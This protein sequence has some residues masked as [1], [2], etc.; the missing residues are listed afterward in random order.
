MGPPKVGGF[1]LITPR[2]SS[3]RSRDN[4]RRGLAAR[5]LPNLDFTALRRLSQRFRPY[6]LHRFCD[7]PEL[8]GTPAQWTTTSCFSRSFFLNSSPRR[9]SRALRVRWLVVIRSRSFRVSI[10]K[11]D[12][13]RQNVASFWRILSRNQLEP[14]V[15]DLGQDLVIG[16]RLFPYGQDARQALRWSCQ[17]QE[18][19]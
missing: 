17:R 13:S 11:L 12:H 15:S 10:R 18:H 5:D 4:R 16:L 2:H 1:P 8:C 3:T 7:G 6:R 9:R 19:S 14:R